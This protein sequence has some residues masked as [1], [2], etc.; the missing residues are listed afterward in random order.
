MNA[1]KLQ[2]T[3]LVTK[4]PTAGPTIFEVEYLKALQKEFEIFLRGSQF[5]TMKEVVLGI[6]GSNYNAVIP[7]ALKD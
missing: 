1:L 7:L 4:K 3:E 5:S 2:Q 6:R